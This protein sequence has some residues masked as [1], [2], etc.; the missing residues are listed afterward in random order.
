M[1]T[2]LRYALIAGSTRNDSQSAKI[3][4]YLAARI[5]ALDPAATATVIDLGHTPIEPW[6]EGLWAG[7]PTSE[8]WN[9]TSATLAAA[10]AF[11]IV[12]PEWNGMAP[13]ALLNV[14][15][16]ASKGELAHKPAMIVG[17]SGSVNG[18]YPVVELRN[19]GLKNT[20]ICYIPDHVIV[21][22][23]AKVLNDG[24]PAS[25][26]DTWLRGRVDYSLGVLGAYASGLRLVRESG[27]IDRKTYPFGM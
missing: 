4:R 14:F 8:A 26:A 5:G 16:M 10:D 27:K 22:D 21:R 24:P 6:H 18:V 9:Q 3:A 1:S 2:A 20:Q 12:A 17:V 11:A 23:A 13:P 15:L 7:A 25:D 19:F